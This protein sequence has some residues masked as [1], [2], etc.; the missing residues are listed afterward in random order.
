M[1][2]NKSIKQSYYPALNVA[3]FI[4]IIAGLIYAH[5]IITP[6]LMA[7]FISIICAQP[8]QWLQ[9]K[10]VNQGLAIVIVFL[11]ILIVFFGFGELVGASLSS[12]SENAPLYE[13][14]LNENGIFADG[15]SK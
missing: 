11:L 6:L 4:I 12:F 13:S 14:N 15:L 10:N 5:S 7:F 1:E 8:I 9:K 3:A 2:S